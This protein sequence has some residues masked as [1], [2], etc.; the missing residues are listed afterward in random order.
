MGSISKAYKFKCFRENEWY[1]GM[2][3]ATITFFAVD[4]FW[5]KMHIPQNLVFLRMISDNL[6][7]A[8]IFSLL[9]FGTIYT[10]LSALKTKKVVITFSENL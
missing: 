1:C 9:V 5:P 6:S 2:F 4:C 10:G 7:P 3:A 8:V